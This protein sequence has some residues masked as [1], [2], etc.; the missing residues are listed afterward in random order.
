MITDLMIDLETLG[1]TPDAAILQIGA[2]AWDMS[3]Q[4][5]SYDQLASANQTFSV[6][7]DLQSS[8]NRGRTVGGGTF[9]FWMRQPDDVRRAVTGAFVP[10]QVAFAQ[11][12]DWMQTLGMI[13]LSNGFEGHVWAWPSQFDLP[14]LA[15]S[16]RAV[17]G[18][19]AKLPWAR[20]ME[21][22]ARTFCVA[23]GRD[24]M[25]GAPKLLGAPNHIGDYDAV[26]QAMEVQSYTRLFP[27][28]QS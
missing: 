11:F 1:E 2:C 27:R 5:E 12:F 8:L 6:A 16:Y 22:D 19:E 4:I 17:R 18:S 20:R 13:K 3:V 15:S 26:A 9:Y 14:I 25:R 7:I 24:E 28:R 23:L 21:R 10:I